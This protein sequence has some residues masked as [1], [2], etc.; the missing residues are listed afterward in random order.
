M[1]AAM[2]YNAD[3]HLLSRFHRFPG[4]PS[5]NLG[6]AVF[7]LDADEGVRVPPVMSPV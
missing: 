7:I 3:E 6:K 4:L 5:S 1:A 2:K